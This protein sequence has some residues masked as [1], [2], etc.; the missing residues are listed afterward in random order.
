MKRK[1]LSVISFLALL[2]CALGST[3]HAQ[4]RDKYLISAKAGGIN[5]VS[6]NVTVN[7]KGGR[8]QQSLTDQ[9]SLESGDVVTTG[10]G[11]RVEVLLNPGSYL[12]VDENSEFELTD[13]SLEHLRIKLVRGSAIIEAVGADDIELAMEVLT[14]Q[15]TVKIVKQGIY[16]INVLQTGA[17]E[18]LVRKG[19]ALVGPTAEVVKG[20]DKITVSGG[21]M[22]VA[23]IDKREQNAFDLWSRDRAEYLASINRGLQQNTV[24]ATI[25]NYYND[26]YWY[27]SERYRRHYGFWA[28]DRNRRCYVFLPSRRGNWSSPY[29]YDYRRRGDFPR[30]NICVGGPTGSGGSGGR[31]NPSSPSGSPPTR[32]GGDGIA[33]GSAPPAGERNRRGRAITGDDRSRLGEDE[34][35]DTRRSRRSDDNSGSRRSSGDDG[36]RAR[37]D[38]DNGSRSRRDSD[39][40]SRGRRDSDDSGSRSSSGGGGGSSSSSQSSSPS[41]S[42]QQSSAPSYTPPPPS[43]PPP[44]RTESPKSETSQGRRE[45]PN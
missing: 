35:T 34:P 20:G 9:D 45:T 30:C 4:T 1:W 16:R 19:R 41:S 39:T 32:T 37:R 22:L 28:F 26:D 31:N 2:V 38:P 27:M 11:G 13:A 7:R 8:T 21:R 10:A 17:T 36:S 3:A 23:K 5:F 15:T 25:N 18:V 43:S 24:Y 42:S 40:G 33:D 29:G 12:R 44:S 14:P 6:G